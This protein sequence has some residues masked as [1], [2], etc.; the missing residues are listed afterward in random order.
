MAEFIDEATSSEMAER[1][2]RRVAEAGVVYLLKTSNGYAQSES[3]DL[4]DDE[5]EPRSV[6]LFFSD[7]GYARAVQR[8]QYP[9]YEVAQMPLF[10]FLYRWL[11]G[12]SGEGVVAGVNWRADLCGPERDPL[13]LCGAIEEALPPEVRAAHRERREQ[14]KA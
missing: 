9:D 3:N 10:D 6:L 2:V 14:E 12:M 5:G 7:A 11:A 1:F 8:A 4:T 13:E